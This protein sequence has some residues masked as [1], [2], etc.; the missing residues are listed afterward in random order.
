MKKKTDN[1]KEKREKIERKIKWKP[2]SKG[3]RKGA[4][5]KCMKEK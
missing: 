5:M 2:S 3:K 4:R 1:G